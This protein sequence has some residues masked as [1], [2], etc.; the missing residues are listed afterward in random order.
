M[1]RRVMTFADAFE[2]DIGK[3]GTIKGYKRQDLK[4]FLPIFIENLADIKENYFSVNEAAK[5][6]EERYPGLW[7]FRKDIRLVRSLSS[8]SFILVGWTQ[9]SSSTRY[10]K[11]FKRDKLEIGQAKLLSDWLDKELPEDLVK[12]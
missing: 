2:Y 11:R 4:E 12:N 8:R 6:I 9:H 5:M 3:K 7:V 10:G 1:T